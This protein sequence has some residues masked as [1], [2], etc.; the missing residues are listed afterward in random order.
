MTIKKRRLYKNRP[1]NI[2]S[3]TPKTRNI[4]EKKSAIPWDYIAPAILFQKYIIV[5]QLSTLK[6]IN[7]DLRKSSLNQFLMKI[8]NSCSIL[9]KG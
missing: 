2:L 7:M 1:F 6:L 4:Q 8:N 3:C 9:Q 5:Q